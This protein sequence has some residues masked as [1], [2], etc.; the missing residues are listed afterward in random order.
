[1]NL[2][3][4]LLQFLS[5]FCLWLNGG[6]AFSQNKKTPEIYLEPIF[7]VNYGDATADK[8]QSKSWTTKHGQWLIVGDE[9]G[10]KLLK[11]ETSGWESQADINEA[12]LNLP[13]RADV[14]SKG[15]E[16]HVLLVGECALSV[17]QITYSPQNMGYVHL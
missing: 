8:P 10:P 16:A 5:F 17:V 12:W 4:I 3:S 2:K 9:D 6:A 1:M 14:W 13:S 7:H 15:D 11:K